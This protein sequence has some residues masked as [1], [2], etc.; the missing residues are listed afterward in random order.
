LAHRASFSG[1]LRVVMEIHQTHWW[2]HAPLS[3]ALT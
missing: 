3:Q 2:R 1:L